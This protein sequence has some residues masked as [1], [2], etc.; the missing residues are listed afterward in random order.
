[1]SR[2]G[3]TRERFDGARDGARDGAAQRQA[4][5]GRDDARAAD[6]DRARQS[7]EQRGFDTPATSNREARDRAGA[8]QRELGQRPAGAQGRAHAGDNAFRNQGGANHGRPPGSRPENAFSGTRN[9]GQS[10][11]DANRGHRSVQS[12]QRPAAARP[13]GRPMSRPAA[14][15]GGGGGGRRR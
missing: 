1:P 5:R 9:P 2:D 11:G 4:Y 15:R 3:A 14:P 6:R 12:S 7:L 13:Q 8:S 10:M